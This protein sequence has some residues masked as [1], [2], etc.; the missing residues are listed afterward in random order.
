M[1][2]RKLPYFGKCLEEEIFEYY[3]YKAST[4][5]ARKL[6]KK[7]GQATLQLQKSPQLGKKE[8]LLTNTK[9][10]YLFIITDN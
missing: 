10:E 3:K 5:I 4:N 7:N 1:L 9:F 6:V 8:E 2:I